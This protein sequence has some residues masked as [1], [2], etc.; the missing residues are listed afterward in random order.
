VLTDCST[1]VNTALPAGSPDVSHRD[2]LSPVALRH[3]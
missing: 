2:A 1:S 3:C